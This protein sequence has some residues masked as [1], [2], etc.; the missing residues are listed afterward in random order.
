[1]S[2]GASARLLAATIFVGG[3]VA[4]A[5]VQ[6]GAANLPVP[7]C[8]GGTPS[9]LPNPLPC[10]ASGTQPGSGQPGS[11]GNNGSNGSNGSNGTN[12]SNRSRHHKKVTKKAK[13]TIK[14][15]KKAKKANKHHRSTR[16][17]RTHRRHR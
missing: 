7:V 8:V 3:A 12:G 4:A 2:R 6:A 5:P 11:N 13:K 16:R 1:M 15:V 9:S 17:G 10:Q 14:K